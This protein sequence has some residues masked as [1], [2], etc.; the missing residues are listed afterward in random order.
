[1]SVSAI[2]SVMAVI[3]ESKT[4]CWCWS[5]ESDMGGWVGKEIIKNYK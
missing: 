3:E 1:M 5:L 4:P 2:L